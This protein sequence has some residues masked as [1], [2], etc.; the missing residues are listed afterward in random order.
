M[1]TTKNIGLLFAFSAF[2]LSL[3]VVGL[4]SNESTDGTYVA[5]AE[6]HDHS[7]MTEWTST[8]S[9]PSSAGSYYLANDVTISSTWTVP[10]GETTLCLNGH[11]ITRSGSG[12]VVIV[13]NV[14][15]VLTIDDHDDL[16]G[17]TGGSNE[18]YGAGVYV[19]NGTFN[20]RGGR[21][22]NNRCSYGNTGGG[23]VETEGTGVFNMY[24]G[25]ITGNQAGYGGAIY[26]RGAIA[27]VYG[28]SITNNECFTTDGGA[29]HAWGGTAVFTMTGGTMTGNSSKYGNGG[30]IGASGGGTINISG[31]TITGNTAHN[32][33]GAIS[34]RRS[35][36]G[37]MEATINISGNPVIKDNTAQNGDGDNIY[38]YKESNTVYPSLTLT[39]ALDE[40]VT[41]EK[42]SVYMSSNDGVMVKNWLDYMEGKDPNDYFA[43]GNPNRSLFINEDGDVIVAEH[44]H[45]GKEFTPWNSNDSLPQTDI[46]GSYYLTQDVVYSSKWVHNS[47]KKVTLCLN[48]HSI[49]YTGTGNGVSVGFDSTLNLVD[50]DQTEH[51]YY[52]VGTGDDIETLLTDDSSNPDYLAATVKGSFKGGYLTSTDFNYDLFDIRTSSVDVNGVHASFKNINIFNCRA[53]AVTT[54]NND[55]CH[56]VV[57]MVG[58]SIIGNPVKSGNALG[59][60]NGAD[61][62]LENTVITNNM[63]GVRVQSTATYPSYLNIGKN[64]KIYGNTNFEFHIGQKGILVVNDDLDNEHTM[65][66]YTTSTPTVVTSGLD[67]HGDESYFT[68]Y[69]DETQYVALNADKE[70]VI[71]EKNSATYAFNSFVWADD[72]MSA[73]AKLVN[74]ADENDYIFATAEMSSAVQVQPT[75]T[76]NG[77]TRYTAKYTATDDIHTDYKDVEIPAGHNFEF[78]GFEWAE[79][80]KSAKAVYTCSGCQAVD[81]KDATVTSAVLTQPTCTVK[82]TTRYTATYEGHTDTKD[83]QD[84]PVIEHTYAF[85]NFE[86]ADDNK[87][88]KAV[89]TCSVCQ[90]TDKKDATMSSEVITPATCTT[91]GVTRYTAT[92][93]NHTDYKDV[94]IPVSHNFE[95]TGFE[96]AEDGKSA[97][98]VYTCSVCQAVDKKDAT[99]TSAVLVQPTCT[100]KGT[101]RYTATYED[102]TDTKDVQDIPVTGHNYEF[103]SFEW[104]SDGKSAK[105]VYT[106]SGCQAVD[107]RDAT[108]TSTVLVQPTTTTK[109]TTRY[110]ATYD[111]HSE[112]KDIQDIPVNVPSSSESGVEVK[113]SEG[114]GLPYNVS[115]KVE[116][117]T[118][119]K[120]EASSADYQKIVANL[121]KNETISNVYDVKLIRT[122]NGV[123]QEIQPSDIKEGTVITVTMELPEGIK[124]GNFRLL[125]IHNADDIEV[126]TNYTIE[127]NKITFNVSRLSQFAFVVKNGGLPGWGVALLIIAIVL[128]LL[129]LCACY[130][131][132]F[133]QRWIIVDKQIVRVFAFGS[134]DGKVRLLTLKFKVFYVDRDHVYLKKIYAEKHL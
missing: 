64:V 129:A 81:K 85:T 118:S 4:I 34:N 49:R 77:V 59:I 66:V 126:I 28:G 125:H 108:V 78:T 18:G 8:N 123:E 93:D 14:S 9:L 114:K 86:W 124:A 80:G 40:S 88:A 12:R 94:E 90:E 97:K 122:V 51:F 91:A 3:S 47:G 104:S 74:T 38:L 25:I 21:I 107:K 115:V 27:N 1:K 121:E 119:V 57:N 54:V 13:N 46:D 110:T 131:Y 120:E 31:G 69:Y 52:N 95:F 10:E 16:G 24:G 76:T 2:T 62:T 11:V 127:G 45:D 92:Y 98:A 26:A 89:Y 5:K 72:N 106:C 15:S 35:S 48:G 33:G 87:S 43:C 113:D 56:C 71:L 99:V 116:L 63:R 30:A 117:K 22:F 96:W 75:C 83:V 42:I 70:L 133:L 67:G 79:D 53:I 58:C 32:Y 128:V 7:Q 103:S 102:H 105:A 73:K 82:G 37:G 109:G 84:I 101:T 23:G 36:G 134:K 6:A 130:I 60:Y 44:Y 112:N 19:P 20:L 65:K 55:A 29:V 39:A 68:V 132:F 111:G 61:V 50:D 41:N 100:V 17:I